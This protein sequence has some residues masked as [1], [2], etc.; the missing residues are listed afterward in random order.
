VI[1][2]SAPG[3]VAD[4]VR[5]VARDLH[6][7]GATVAAITEDASLVDAA[8]LV[9]PIRPGL[10]EALVGLPGVIRGQQLA[11]AAAEV[12]GIDPDTPFALAKVTRTT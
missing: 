9:V 6:D 4:D 2:L 10:P 12:R 3:P 7:R 5:D 11:L 8:D 1:C